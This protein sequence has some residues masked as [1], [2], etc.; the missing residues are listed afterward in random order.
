MDKE[1]FGKAGAEI[2]EVTEEEGKKMA[3]DCPGTYVSK[4]E[5]VLFH[6]G[7]SNKRPQTGCF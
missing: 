3:Q 2:I 7:C 6:L 1:G 4:I 5:V